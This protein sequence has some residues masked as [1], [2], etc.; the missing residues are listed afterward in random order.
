MIEPIEKMLELE[1]RGIVYDAKATLYL[2]KKGIPSIS[3]W[4]LVEGIHHPVE[5]TYKFLKN[6]WVKSQNNNP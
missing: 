1:K 6:K 2:D 3:G 4:Y 5:V